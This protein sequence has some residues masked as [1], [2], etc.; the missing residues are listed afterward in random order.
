MSSPLPLA[1]PPADPT[2]I[3]ID[4]FT[5]PSI[6]TSDNYL[7]A[8]DLILYW[9]CRPGFSTGHLDTAL[10]MDSMNALASQFWEG[11]LL[12][13]LKDGPT[14]FLFVNTGSTYYDRGF[15]MLQIL[16]D[17]FCP[18]S[19]SNT[20]T[21]LLSLFND[22]QSDKEG[23]HE[24]HSQ[25]EGN[26][27]ALSH[28]SVTIPQ[29]LQVMLFLHAIH[30]CYQD[31]LNKFASKQKDLSVASIDS[32]V[33]NAKFIDKF[34]AIGTNGEPVHPPS[35]PQ[36]PAVATALTGCKG[37]EHCSSWEWL[38]AFDSND[39][40]SC[41]HQSLCGGFYCAVCHSKEKHHPLKC[42][43]LVALN[44]KLIKVRGSSGG[45]GA[46]SKSPAGGPSVSGTS[47]IPGAKVAAVGYPAAPSN[48]FPPALV[49][50]T[51]AVVAEGYSTDSFCWEGDEDG[52]TYVDALKPKASVS[53]YTPLSPGS[54]CCRVSI[55]P[56]PPIPMCL[57]S[58][59]HQH[60]PPS[61]VGSV[62]VESHS[63][64]KQWYS[65]PSRCG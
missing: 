13:A 48:D 36:A 62:V 35:T 5:L 56:D 8:R 52:I 11:Q 22:K 23:V 12:T 21:T 20:F 46:D 29:I 55:E 44:L 38:A 50:M 65:F 32:V 58:I 40:L 25:F 43:M 9:L 47:G 6:K 39:M 16:E 45:T 2:P 27:L 34:V 42:P 18:S 49:R 4:C 14:R 17:N 7:A 1:T 10:I 53:P 63:Y 41:W 24:F 64:Y 30:P 54:L 59:G 57:A 51:A 60:C 26:L 31:L 61:H 28:S 19:I 3:P 33:A 15:E 37:K